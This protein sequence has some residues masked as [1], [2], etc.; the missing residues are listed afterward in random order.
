MGEGGCTTPE[1]L[2]KRAWKKRSI[3]RKHAREIGGR[4][5]RCPTCQFHHI[6][7]TPKRAEP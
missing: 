5:Y 2:H 3:A 7:K 1:G 6:T 4:S